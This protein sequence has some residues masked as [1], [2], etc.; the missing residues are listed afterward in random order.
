MFGICMCGWSILIRS[1]D[2]SLIIEWIAYIF[3]IVTWYMSVCEFFSVPAKEDSKFPL[4]H[5]ANFF[6]VW[7]NAK[8]VM[9]FIPFDAT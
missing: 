6:C 2:Y 8:C 3:S 9:K 1:K 5:I 4:D 7:M